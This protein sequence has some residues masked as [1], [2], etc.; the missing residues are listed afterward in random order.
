EELR[1]ELREDAP[2]TSRERSRIAHREIGFCDAVVRG[3]HPL[4]I[5][6][7]TYRVRSKEGRDQVGSPVDPFAGG[8][9]V[10]LQLLDDVEDLHEAPG[11]IGIP[12]LDFC[13]GCIHTELKTLHVKGLRARDA[14]GMI[15]H[16]LVQELELPRADP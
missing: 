16:D 11:D 14:A 7:N 9:A 8:K 12:R 4:D 13:E 5:L 10:A 15:A 2:G 6:R 1:H 3:E